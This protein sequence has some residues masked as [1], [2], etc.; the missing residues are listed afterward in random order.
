MRSGEERVLGIQAPLAPSSQWAR[1]LE[2]LNGGVASGEQTHS[3]R[4][5]RADTSPEPEPG[6]Q[7]VMLPLPTSPPFEGGGGDIEEVCMCGIG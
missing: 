1:I 3:Q 5:G 4:L 7:T 2:L 6:A